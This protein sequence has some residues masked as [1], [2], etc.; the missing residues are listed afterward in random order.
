MRREEHVLEAVSAKNDLIASGKL[1]DTVEDLIPGVLGHETDE[2][3]KT[4]Y[5]L[6]IEMVENGRCEGIDMVTLTPYWINI[7]SWFKQRT[8]R[9]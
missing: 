5:R 8:Y 4:D 3:I 1:V 9:H 2:R 6:L 7:L